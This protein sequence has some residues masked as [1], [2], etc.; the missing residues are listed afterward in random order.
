[1]G[2]YC[3]PLD[4]TNIRNVE[5]GLASHMILVRSGREASTEYEPCLP[6]KGFSPYR[7]GVYLF[8]LNVLYVGHPIEA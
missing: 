2:G 1:M 5:S 8:V 4:A 7:P 6:G 3:K